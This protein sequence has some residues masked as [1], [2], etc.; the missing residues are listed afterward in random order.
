M[1]L[2]RKQRR[3]AEKLKKQLN[4][5]ALAQAARQFQKDIEQNG[6]FNAELA[7][8][9]KAYMAQV[10]A[11]RAKQRE[12][13]S[14]N[15]ITAD[16]LNE[17]YKRGYAAARSDL[18]DFM[19]VNFYASAGIAL[20]ELFKFGEERIIRVLNRMQLVMTEEITSD[21]LIERLKRETGVDIIAEEYV[22]G[23]LKE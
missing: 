23:G 12:G 7:N 11:A 8:R 16:D 19:Q 10:V 21:D 18:V 20:R 13:W 14:K 15:G 2:N 9:D 1:Q 4:R 22:G 5:D 3:E 6:I 17:A